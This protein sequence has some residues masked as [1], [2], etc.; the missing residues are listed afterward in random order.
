M[1]AAGS[2]RRATLRLLALCALA[3]GQ[4]H[5][6]WVSF[7]AA[8]G[9]TSDIVE[10][11]DPNVPIV[12]VQTEASG[13]GSLGLTGY[14]S[15]DVVNLATGVGSGF[16]TF[17]DP[18]GNELY[19]SFTVQLLPGEGALLLLLGEMTFTGGTGVF[20]GASG[21]A[22]FTGRARFE[23]QT[24]ALSSFFFSGN[25][26]TVDA[27][28]TAGLLAAGIGMFLVQKRRRRPAASGAPGVVHT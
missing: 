15:G 13:L 4:A 21:S 27:P 19:G 8:M 2:L 5:A 3:V 9:G 11:I 14:R 18:D 7:E 22:T 24:H 16:N 12:R 10:V 1:S 23:S 25:L 28:P 20:A 26:Q 17:F 6:D